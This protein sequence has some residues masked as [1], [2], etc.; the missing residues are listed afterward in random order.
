M[1]T[2]NRAGRFSDS[3]YQTARQSGAARR[4]LFIGFAN[5]LS[6]AIAAVA[7]GPQLDRVPSAAGY[8]AIRGALVLVLGKILE[9]VGSILVAL[10]GLQA[11]I[12]DLRRTPTHAANS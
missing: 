5:R 12:L 6:N 10:V 11:L 8:F 4:K 1:R 3:Q 9:T 2:S 7:A